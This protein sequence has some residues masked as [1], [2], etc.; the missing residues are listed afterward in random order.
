[1]PDD[2]EAPLEPG[3][4]NAGVLWTC[5]DDRNRSANSDEGESDEVSSSA[6]HCSTRW[7]KLMCRSGRLPRSSVAVA[8]MSERRDPPGVVLLLFTELALCSASEVRTSEGRTAVAAAAVS[9]VEEGEEEEKSPGWCDE[10]LARW[11][12]AR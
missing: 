3:T 6:M 8:K 7:L 12:A 2:E 10:P 9:L 4:I 11:T 5:C 1:V